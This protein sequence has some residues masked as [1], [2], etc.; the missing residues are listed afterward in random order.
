M[1][2]VVA[3]QADCTFTISVSKAL[4][5]L[6]LQQ[7]IYSAM[8]VLKNMTGI[9][10]FIIFVAIFSFF[11]EI[12]MIQ[13]TGAVY[14]NMNGLWLNVAMYYLV[15][16]FDAITFQMIF[17][18]LFTLRVPNIRLWE[19]IIGKCIESNLSFYGIVS[20]IWRQT[21]EYQH[22][23]Y[24]PVVFCFWLNKLFLSGLWPKHETAK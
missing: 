13:R 17:H 23:N 24:V 5:M 15:Q 8:P 19:V 11:K 9:H 12:Q 20:K 18:S 21:E 6:V 16:H 14:V 1:C 22:D 10:V 7:I 4:N 3:I 2:V